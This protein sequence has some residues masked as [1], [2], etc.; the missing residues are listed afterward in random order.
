[1][2]VRRIVRAPI[3]SPPSP[4]PPAVTSTT[5][6]SDLSGTTRSIGIQVDRFSRPGRIPSLLNLVTSSGPARRGPTAQ[7]RHVWQ[8][9]VG[10]PV[11]TTPRHNNPQS[12]PVIV[13]SAPPLEL[14][15]TPPV[16]PVVKS[17]VLQQPTRREAPCTPPHRTLAE[18]LAHADAQNERAKEPRDNGLTRSS[19]TGTITRESRRSRGF[20]AW[21]RGTSE[22]TQA[23]TPGHSGEVSIVKMLDD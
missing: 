11:C 18:V 12:R 4:P 15:D 3:F 16:A 10:L 22:V 5:R 14:E 23:G 6:V 17:A 2:P 7:S 9:L 21:R 1:M 19:S 20:S 13:P 8:P